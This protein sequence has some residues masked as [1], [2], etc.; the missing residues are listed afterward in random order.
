MEIHSNALKAAKKVKL[1]IFDVDGVLTDGGIYI[2]EKGELYKPFN[3]RDG[4]GITLAHKLGLKTAIITG[5]QSKQVAY[6]ARELKISEVFQGNSDKRE[7]YNELKKHT[8]FRDEEIAYI[9][10]DLIDLP[11]MLGVM[12]ILC[13][14]ALIKGELKR[15]QGVTLLCAYAAFTVYQFVS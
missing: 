3:C 5:R 6:R 4:L 15:W 12:A 7:A 8:G 1:V 11:I 14:P 13:L 10:D 9:G 2:G